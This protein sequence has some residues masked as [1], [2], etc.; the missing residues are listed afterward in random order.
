M[1]K[2][3]ERNGLAEVS[4]TIQKDGMTDEL[5]NSLWNILHIPYWN[6]F[7]TGHQE[8]IFISDFIKLLQQ[9][10]LKKPIDELPNNSEEQLEF[11][12]KYFYNCKWYEIYDFL[13]FFYKYNEDENLEKNINA[14][15]KRELSAYRL[16]DGIFADIT[17]EQEIEALEQALA[18][19]RFKGVQEHFK[20][21]LKL[22]SD[23]KDPDYRNSIKES[24][25]AVESMCK[26]ITGE[27]GS[28]LGK[29]LNALEKQGKLHKHLKDGFVKLYAYTNDDGIRHAIM[30]ESN[31][32]ADDAKYFLLS[33]TSFINYLKTKI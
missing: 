10:H 4:K 31:I 6:N 14:I 17:D 24:I 5:R 26:I 8:I 16:I 32:D 29:A 33:C 2:F 28:T 1:Q 23:R 25:S 9:F 22:L 30:K 7:F 13:E 20:T 3:S 11:I 15:L 19:D 21:A 18:D 12:K 27:N